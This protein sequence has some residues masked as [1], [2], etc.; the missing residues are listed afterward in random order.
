MLNQNYK[1][2]LIYHYHLPI[3]MKDNKYKALKYWGIVINQL[4]KYFKLT[5]I[6][7]LGE[8]LPSFS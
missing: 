6:A 2:S 1:P 3:V 4:S 5:L 7:Y 8:S